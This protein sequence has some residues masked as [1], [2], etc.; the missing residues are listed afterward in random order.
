M[1]RQQGGSK[2]APII[3]VPVHLV[4]WGLIALRNLLI[5]IWQRITSRKD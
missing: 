3:E 4:N 1:P 2:Y 5:M